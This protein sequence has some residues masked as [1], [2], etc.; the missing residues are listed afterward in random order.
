MKSKFLLLLGVSGVGKSTIIKRLRELDDRFT[1][2]SPY[3]TRPLR[4]GEI[5]K[6]SISSDEMDQLIA[7]GEILVVNEIYGI[8]YAT[9]SEPIDGAFATGFFPLLDWPI[10]KLAIMTERFGNQIFT[11]YIEPPTI[12]ELKRRLGKDQRDRSGTRLLEAIAELELLGKGRFDD[13]CN[14]RLVLDDNV[15]EVAEMIYRAFIHSLE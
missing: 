15:N 4:E 10:G 7:S 8:R 14:I 12:T 6:K 2:I 3:V 5:D 1:Y 9:P 11:V 13:M